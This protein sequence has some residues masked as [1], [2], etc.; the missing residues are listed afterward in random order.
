VD[1][2]VVVPAE[3]DHV[4]WLLLAEAPVGYMMEGNAGALADETDLGEKL[5]TT[6]APAEAAPMVA[7]EVGAV[8]GVAKGKEAFTERVHVTDLIVDLSLL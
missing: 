3:G 2:F 5:V 7:V 8:G 6:V 4:G 1:G